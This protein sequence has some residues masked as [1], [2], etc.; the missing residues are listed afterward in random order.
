[1]MEI[2]KHHDMEVLSFFLNSMAKR[3]VIYPYSLEFAATWP[4]A[5]LPLNSLAQG[6][7]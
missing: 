7:F 4:A 2:L 1:M 3:F 6:R 5:Y